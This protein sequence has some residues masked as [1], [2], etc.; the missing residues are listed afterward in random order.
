MP[1][2]GCDQQEARVA[3]QP[4]KV[5]QIWRQQQQ[6]LLQQR[7]DV[8]QML[9]ILSSVWHLAPH[10]S[11]S[12]HENAAAMNIDQPEARMAA[13]LLAAAAAAAVP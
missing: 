3:T 13:Q 11:I 10:K 8:T 4:F 12:W 1:V 9:D 7:L 6:L 5:K 2:M